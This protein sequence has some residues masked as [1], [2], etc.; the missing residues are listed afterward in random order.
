[1]GF[2]YDV[3]SSIL[4]IVIF[5]IVY[6]GLFIASIAKKIE[7]NWPKYK[8]QPA[9]IPLAGYFGKDTLQ[10]FTECI[11]D[12]QGGFM[13]IFLGPLK[14]AMKSLGDIGNGIIGS[15]NTLRKMFKHLT[16]ALFKIFG[17]LFGMINNLVIRFQQ[18]ITSLKDIVMK[19]V[20][21]FYTLIM[22]I[23]GMTIFGESVMAGPIGAFLDVLCFSPNTKIKLLKGGYKSMKDLSLGEILEDGSEVKGILRIKG[24][25]KDKYYKIYSKKLNDY[26][27][28]TGTHL[29]MHPKTKEFIKVEH[30]EDAILTDR[31]DEEL[32]CLVTSTH[33]IPIGEYTFWDWED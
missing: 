33:K 28:V 26:I 23:R 4:I 14:H 18:M 5:L 12:I 22:L 11:G 27:Y 3:M 17:D 29:I 21:V 19:M 2:F 7:E 9:M 6:I 30:Y 32:S 31:W 10:N 25:E 13:D 16:D 24:N 15:I 8:C 20:G 1:M